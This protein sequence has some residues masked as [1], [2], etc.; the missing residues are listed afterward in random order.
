MARLRNR[1]DGPACGRIRF[2]RSGTPNMS[3]A[4]KHHQPY[5][6]YLEALDEEH[7]HL[8]KEKHHDPIRDVQRDEYRAA[9]QAYEDELESVSDPLD[10]KLMAL[11]E[12]LDAKESIYRAAV[13]KRLHAAGRTALCFSGGG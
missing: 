2:K 3:H 12:A 13:R 4:P 8:E 11:K 6:T 7:W 9:L 10:P 1:V 5:L